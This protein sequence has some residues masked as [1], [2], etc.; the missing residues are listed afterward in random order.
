MASSF[1]LELQKAREYRGMTL[2]EVSRTTKINVKYLRALE[3]E[4]FDVLPEPYVKAFIKA[5]AEVVGMN[6][7]KVMSE[8]STLI[9]RGGLEK[10]KPPAEPQ[11]ES[12]VK[13]DFEPILD[14]FRG[15]VKK[16]VIALSSIAV[17]VVA[18]LIISFLPSEE[19]V[20]NQVESSSVV[21]LEGVNLSVTANKSLYLMVS[22][23][24][25][26]S[27]DYFLNSEEKK[28]FVAENKI[29]ALTSDAGATVVTCKDTI[30]IDIGGSGWASHF[31]VDTAGVRDIR[32]YQPLADMTQ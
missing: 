31:T 11:S 32:T 13:F 5:Y 18:A 30:Q 6:V 23:D 1:G 4:E 9:H 20:E 10:E 21:P 27:L 25:G 7:L 2:E 17:V 14:F 26:D 8:F 19:A 15:N 28:D 22:I 16:I 3:D 24:G 12:S 29:W